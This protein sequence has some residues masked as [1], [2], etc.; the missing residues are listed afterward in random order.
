MLTDTKCRNAK[1]KAEPYKLRDG[2]GLYLEVKPNG[3]KS[4]RYR[5]KL[6]KGDHVSESMYAIGDYAASPAG[7][8]DEQAAARR[9]AG[10]YTLD[11]ARQERHRARGLVKQGI[12]P[13]H[14]RQQQRQ[15]AARDSETTFEAVART[16]VIG[17]GWMQDTKDERLR[18]LERVV[19]PKIGAIPVKQIESPAILSLLKAAAKKNGP[20]VAAQAKA[21]IYKVFELAR[22]EYGVAANPVLQW[23]EALP[24]NK[25]QHKR[26]LTPQEIGE[27]LRALDGHERNI[28]TVAA[29]RLL[30]LTLCRPIEAV[31]ARWGEIDLEAATWTIGAERMK[32]RIEHRVP[33][34]AQAVEVLKAMQPLTGHRTH[35]FPH[36]DRRDEAMTD[37]NLRQ[38]L[39][40][41]G[42]SGRYSPH[43]TRTT[44]STILNEHGYPADWI[45][46]QLAHG[47]PNAVRRTYNHAQ[48]FDGRARMM[49]SWADY[50][51]SLKRGDSKVVL[52][53]SA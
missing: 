14:H 53:R 23:Q 42:W 15:R 48:H 21:T 39:H 11:E 29:F 1:P 13:A 26:A 31:G 51:D 46:R 49:Q 17:K 6:A 32:K 22:E 52:L 37:A 9:A 35:V 10:G 20:T 38:T 24:K 25:T 12:N 27:F 50:L 30:W 8:T 41:M 16:W 19:F 45:E 43:A 28:Q 5:F 36:R 34:P 7:E 18:M 47:E 4:W 33:L 3:T 2:K 40:A 44:G